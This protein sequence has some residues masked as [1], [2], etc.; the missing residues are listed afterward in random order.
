MSK[1]RRVTYAFAAIAALVV[2]IGLIAIS[3][4]GAASSAPRARA[5]P[6]APPPT[7]QVCD[8]AGSQHC[9]NR[10]RN[11]LS[12]GTLIIGWREGDPNNDFQWLEVAGYCGTG[13][14]TASCPSWG[15]SSLNQSYQGSVIVYNYS[16]GKCLALNS[17]LEPCGSDG[18]V[19]VLTACG[20]DP[21]TCS[22]SP[23]LNSY[24]T[25]KNRAAR[26]LNFQLPLG[27]KIIL[28]G[29]SPDNLIQFHNH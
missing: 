22:F 11:G 6:A 14:V 25:G 29:S 20:G 8:S 26:W 7:W 16:H 12:S 4:A 9:M 27:A 19:D 24:W 21:I 18:T 23:V 10:N 17:E 3:P 2:S 5:A 15:N 1:I 28:T 13:H